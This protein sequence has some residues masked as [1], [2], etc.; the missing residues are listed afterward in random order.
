MI[1]PNS[2][3]PL[4]LSF[5]GGMVLCTILTATRPHAWQYVVLGVLVTTVTFIVTTWAAHASGH[6]RR[7]HLRRNGFIPGSWAR[8]SY[9]EYRRKHGEFVPVVDPVDPVNPVCPIHNTEDL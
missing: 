2:T 6:W 8:R 5:L 3:F 1:T 4:G 7:V 9:Q